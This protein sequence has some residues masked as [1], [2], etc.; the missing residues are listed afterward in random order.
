MQATNKQRGSNANLLGSEALA[1][2]SASRS[3]RHISESKVGPQASRR[4]SKREGDGTTD[5][6]DP[7]VVLRGGQ[8]KYLDGYEESPCVIPQ[9]HPF[10]KIW[11][12][13]MLALLIFTAVV[14]PFEV[15]FLASTE[16]DAMF[17][18]N[19]VVSILFLSDLI[20]NFFLPYIDKKTGVEVD[21]NVDIAYSYLT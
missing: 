17:F 13:V 7:G 16:Y 5:G 9:N 1:A 4:F 14:T 20:I 8:V 6:D 12:V 11:D 10:M 18:V 21:D 2:G 3:Q 15:A 19:V